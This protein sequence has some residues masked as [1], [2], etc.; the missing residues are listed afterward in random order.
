MSTDAEALRDYAARLRDP[1]FMRGIFRQ[2][3][4]Q[5]Q[6]GVDVWTFLA[7][8]RG[9]ADTIEQRARGRRARSLRATRSGKAL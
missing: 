4:E 5:A 9:F 3:G 7:D 1:E 2:I 6:P 8:A